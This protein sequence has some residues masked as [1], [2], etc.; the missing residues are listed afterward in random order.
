MSASVSVGGSLPAPV[1]APLAVTG[2]YWLC[3]PFVF[4]SCQLNLLEVIWCSEHPGL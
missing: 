1:K 3:L 4:S 2:W